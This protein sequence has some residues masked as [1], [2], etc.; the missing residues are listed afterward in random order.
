MF[1][2]EISITE[3]IE[4]I[5]KKG[6]KLDEALS[7]G[8]VKGSV[9]YQYASEFLEGSEDECSISNLAKRLKTRLIRSMRNN[10]KTCIN[11][12]I[13]TE[14]ISKEPEI[15]IN[16]L[17]TFHLVYEKTLSFF[18]VFDSSNSVK[19][20]LNNLLVEE[21]S[22]FEPAHVLKFTTKKVN[23]NAIYLNAQCKFTDCVKV[24]FIIK[25]DNKDGYI[26]I[27]R[28]YGKI[29]CLSHENEKHN[30]FL[31][32]Q[33]REQ[34]KSLLETKKASVVRTQL[35]NSKSNYEMEQGNYSSIFSKEVLRKARSEMLGKFDLHSDDFLDIY[36]H[37]KSSDFILYCGAPFTVITMSYSQVDVIKNM[38]GIHLEFDA[39]GS[40]IR[41]PEKP[42]KAVLYYAGV[43]NTDKGVLPL[44]DM[45]TIDQS[46]D[47]I[48][49]FLLSVRSHIQKSNI[50]WP[51]FQRISSDFS[52]ASL[53][54]LS[55]AFNRLKLIDYVNQCYVGNLDSGII[56]ISLC[57]SHFIKM[58][59]RKLSTTHKTMGAKHFIA[60]CLGCL[61][62][63]SN[64]EIF[65]KIVKSLFA[66]LNSM[67]AGPLYRNNLNIIK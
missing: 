39:T 42:G 28:M 47:N 54:A 51:P 2:D 46:S 19:L 56:R 10:T 16:K 32:G 67:Y 23:C 61:I 11:S 21:F 36:L 59:L 24:S 45:A 22:R 5:N 30:T 55:N 49:K 37:Q 7:H 1:K 41:K 43:I 25:R 58:I 57:S 44:F 12:T 26:A 34:L 4:Y 15:Q 31:K 64:F 50:H 33:K 63:E 27:A 35:I 17:N 53:H 62:T 18:D 8:R 65:T 29:N 13:F 9:F 66:I 14:V 3:I 20:S 48:E 52:F 60:A 6:L 40:V 38:K